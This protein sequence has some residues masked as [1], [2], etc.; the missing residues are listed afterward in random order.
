M[1]SKLSL[2]FC[3]W[4][5]KLSN[6]SDSKEVVSL[7]HHKTKYSQL[8]SFW[9]ISHY[10]SHWRECITYNVKTKQT[11]INQTTLLQGKTRNLWMQKLNQT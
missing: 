9:M 2:A 8:F 11:N 4:L 5:L 3:S 6:C 1:P 10:Q 7:V